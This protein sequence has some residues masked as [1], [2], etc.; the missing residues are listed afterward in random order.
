MDELPWVLLG[1]LTALK[2]DLATS[3]AELMYGVRL[4]VPG[5]FIPAGR[6]LQDPPSSILLRLHEMM[7][8]LSPVPTLRH[9]LTPGYRPSHLQTSKYVFIHRVSLRTP[10]QKSYV[11]PFRVLEH[12]PKAFIIDYGR[13]SQ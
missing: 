1:I 4:I 7:G 13:R 9:G 8:T 6:D 3:F 2:E 10:L 5:D 12:H 11:G